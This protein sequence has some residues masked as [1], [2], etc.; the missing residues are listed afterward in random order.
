VLVVLGLAAGALAF[1]LLRYWTGFI[2]FAVAALLA[3]VQLA[4]IRLRRG[5]RGGSGRRW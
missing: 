1:G 4:R 2:L 5:V 3:T